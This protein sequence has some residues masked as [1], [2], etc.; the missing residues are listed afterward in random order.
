ML[1]D[2]HGATLALE[3]PMATPSAKR[4]SRSPQPKPQLEVVDPRWLIKALV[5][6]LAVAASFAYLAVCLLL[7]QGG[8]QLLL[9]PSAAVNRTPSVPF[10]TIRFDAAETGTP[11]LTGWWIPAEATPLS[12][13]ARTILFLHDGS[14]SL[15]NAVPE[16]DLLHRA[17]VNIFAID[18][19]GFGHSDPPHPTEAR[20]AED[21]A[22]ALDFLANTRHIALNRIIPY[23]QGLG[24]VLAA[25][26]SDSHAAIPALILDDPDPDAFAN[27]T[28]SGKSRF[29]PMRTLV[30]EHF[31]L[32]A[33]L[34]KNRTPKLLLA[35]TPFDPDPARTRTN[36]AFF[37]T[38]PNPKLAVTF[39]PAAE[40]DPNSGAYVPSTV[41]FLDEY[42]PD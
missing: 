2:V 10:E 9:H 34:A 29:L 36:Q 31:D 6:T 21:A 19:R 4:P 8:W 39:N 3:L 28:S 22:A 12:T 5:I 16:L 1:T 41:R 38:V 7:Y 24:A 27:V 33:A 42:V 37:R 15:S 17:N 26:L 14:G 40:A 23:G 11:R 20:M 30:Q 32:A 35:N 18:Y 13:P 25:N